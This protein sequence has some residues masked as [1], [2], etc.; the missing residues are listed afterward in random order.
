MLF[1]IEEG[2]I[3][4]HLDR[5]DTE[6]LCQNQDLGKGWDE[7]LHDK[8]IELRGSIQETDDLVKRVLLLQLLGEKNSGINFG[9]SISTSS[10]TPGG[11]NF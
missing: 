10:N 1:Y 11:W 2:S 4:Y 8:M 5:L 6:L 9:S 7:I 3:G